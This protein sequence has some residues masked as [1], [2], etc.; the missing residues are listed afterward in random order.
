MIRRAL[1]LPTL[2]CAFT[3][4]SCV[5][6]P[7]ASRQADEAAKSI[8]VPPGKARLYC[9]RPSS[10]WRGVFN[11]VAVDGA[12]LSVIAPGRYV[13]T[14]VDPGCHVVF[15]D[16]YLEKT[17]LSLEHCYG[18]A[19]VNLAVERDRA[20]FV[21]V[22]SH[23][24]RALSVV[25]DSA[26]TQDILRSRLAIPVVRSPACGIPPAHCTSSPASPPSDR[27][28]VALVFGVPTVP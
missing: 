7:K 19:T 9:Y 6:V 3:V 14:D 28:L 20:Y 5:S 18:S 27:G 15:A 17:L 25:P 10:F 2:A 1:V 26:G 23:K 13:F 21:K 8:A 11:T 24:E 22:Q 16:W 4:T 12:V